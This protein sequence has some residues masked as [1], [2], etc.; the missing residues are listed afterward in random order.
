MRMMAALVVLTSLAGCAGYNEARDA[1]LAAAAQERVAADDAKC[2]ASGLQPNTPQYDD[3][4]KRLANEQASGTRG[5]QRMIDMM[6][7]D[8]P[9]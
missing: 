7:N 2:Q 1:N 4:R 8:R 5:H 3:C 6:L 9:R